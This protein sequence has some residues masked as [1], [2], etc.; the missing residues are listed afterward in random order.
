MNS[1]GDSYEWGVPDKTGFKKAIDQAIEIFSDT[2]WD[3]QEILDYSAMGWNTGVGMIVYQT[4]NMSLVEQFRPIL[5]TLDILGLRYESYPTN[6]LLQLCLQANQ[7]AEADVLV[8]K[9]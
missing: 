8:A 3:R 2:D 4:D 6:S 1:R 7:P 5:R 9:V